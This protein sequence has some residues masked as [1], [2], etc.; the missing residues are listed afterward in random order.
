MDKYNKQDETKEE[1][2]Q[3]IIKRIRNL[4]E[5]ADVDYDE[6]VKALGASKCGYS[7]I[8]RRDLD[9]LYI[10]SYNIEWIRAWNG[11]MDIQIV[12]DYF[13]VITYVTDYYSK[14][15]S[16]TMELIKAVVDQ[17]DAKD[18]KEK[19]RA[20]SNAFMTHRQMG[21][22]EAVYKLLP[23]MTL[24]KSNVACQW[25]SLGTI[26]D[27]SSRWRLANES[28]RP[29]EERPQMKDRGQQMRN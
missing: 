4:C 23:S 14:D 19:M 28:W 18:I 17:S 10:N 11:N 5:V 25:V 24:K 8:Q 29:G 22:A 13:A 2:Q 7:I 16:G 21:E 26:E 12:L 15:E 3:N 1:Y 9:E 6:Y 20:V 27:R